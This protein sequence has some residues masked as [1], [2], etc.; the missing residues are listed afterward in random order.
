M[1]KGLPSFAIVESAAVGAG[2]PYGAPPA[3]QRG[4]DTLWREAI[5]EML[6]WVYPAAGLR[7]E[8]VPEHDVLSTAIDYAVDQAEESDAARPPDSIVPSGSG[9]IAMEWNDGAITLIV[10]FVKQGVANYTEFHEGKI[11]RQGLLVRNP[12]SRRLELRG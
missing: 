7:L 9:R 2:E 3:P 4:D 12:T 8:D 6:R 10:E 1:S 5:D 11:Y